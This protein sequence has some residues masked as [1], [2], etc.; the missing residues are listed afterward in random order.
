MKIKTLTKERIQKYLDFIPLVILTISA[1]NLI[2]EATRADVILVWKHYVGLILLPVN[3][4]LFFKN[5]RVAVVA[6][7]LT[8][9]MGLV[10]LLSF[11]PSVVTTKYS[12]GVKDVFEVPL[13]YGQAIFLIW[14]LIHFL[15]SGRFYFAVLTRKYWQDLIQEIKQL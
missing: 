6:L 7:G 12:I 11:S 5:H 13:F 4:M 14:L 3:Y 8:L 9:C 2:G 15:V 10:S 1:L